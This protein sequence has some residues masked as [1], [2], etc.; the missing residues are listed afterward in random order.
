MNGLTKSLVSGS[1]AG[2]GGTCLGTII[3]IISFIIMRKK[4]NSSGIDDFIK[5]FMGFS[6]GIM[7]VVICFDLLPG[8]FDYAGYTIGTMAIIVGCLTIPLFEVLINCF[9]SSNTN[10][11]ISKKRTFKYMKVSVIVFIGIALHNFPEG[12][13]VGSGFNATTSYGIALAIIIAIHDIPEGIA[14]AVPM[15]ALNKNPIKI[16]GISFLAGLPT[17]IGAIIGW[18]VAGI[19][20]EFIGMCLGFAGG[21]MLYVVIGQLFPMS[22]ETKSPKGMIISILLGFISGLFIINIV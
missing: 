3:A 16:I 21:A 10:S 20:S 4:K 6:G 14:L 9:K 7:M 12:L 22:Y 5:I 11:S 8:A 18:Y 2:I 15:I 19:S 17:V 13:A 1:L